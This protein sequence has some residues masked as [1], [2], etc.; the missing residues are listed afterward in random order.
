MITERPI[1][2]VTGAS[3]GVGK[4]V[5]RRLIAEGHYVILH[6]RN[7]SKL[8]MVLDELTD[9]C[10]ECV[11]EVAIAD[12]SSLADVRR[13]ADDISGRFD[14]L[15]LLINNA[16]IG[17]ADNRRE[18]SADGIELRFAVN[19]LSHFLL[20]HQLLPCLR[21]AN[22]GRIVSVSSAGQA[23][24]DFDDVMLERG[25]SGFQAYCQSKL[26]QIMFTRDL[27]DLLQGTTVTATALHP[28]TFMN[29]KIVD[30]PLSTVE[31]GARAIMNLATAPETAHLNGVYY[32]ELRPGQAHAQADD[33]DARRRLRKLS[34]HLIASA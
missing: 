21:A 17:I 18:E 24:I 29:T 27:A 3:D 26:A 8:E 4:E 22:A 10:D 2:L 1:S 25:Y 12:L 23:P 13:L 5:A 19:Y 28:A 7:P 16:G 30:T 15:D 20:T 32:N 11:A 9:G 14:H 31:D 6:G 34:E 33:P